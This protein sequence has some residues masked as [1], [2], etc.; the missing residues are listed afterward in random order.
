MRRRLTVASARSSDRPVPLA[1]TAFALRSWLGE[2]G[3]PA[4]HLLDPSSSSPAF[5]GLVQ[6]TAL[7]PS[8]LLAEIH[9]KAAILSGP[10]GAPKWLPHGGVIVLDDG[11]YRVMNP[12]P[13]VALSELS[14]YANSAPR[15]A[16]KDM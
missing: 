12:P 15:L 13:M 3:R 9:A 10:R 16:R 2:D 14:G 11:S 7:A 5:T 6:V 4:H 1:A 8:A